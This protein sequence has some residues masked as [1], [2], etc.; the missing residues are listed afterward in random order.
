MAEIPGAGISVRG[1]AV[2]LKIVEAAPAEFSNMQ[3]SVQ[4]EIRTRIYRPK[5][6][7]SEPAI[8]DRQILVHKFYYR[9]A[10]L[11]ALRSTPAPTKPEQT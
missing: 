4:R 10:D 7:E 11:D 5:F 9:Q 8:A 3:R 2:N 1:R 6:V